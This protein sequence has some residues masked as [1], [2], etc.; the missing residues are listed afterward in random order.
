MSTRVAGSEDGAI[1]GKKR[2]PP[3]STTPAPTG[4]TGINAVTIGETD[5]IKAFGNATVSHHN[6]E[7]FNNALADRVPTPG[8]NQTPAP[9]ANPPGKERSNPRDKSEPPVCTFCHKRGH[10]A[11][12]CYRRLDLIT[13]ALGAAGRSI[14]D[15]YNATGAQPIP[16][17]AP[18]LVAATPRG[19]AAGAGYR[20]PKK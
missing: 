19:P 14:D 12:V 1:G 5:A 9:P 8:G 10:D 15:L 11:K 16:M 6:K 18:A 3:R 17:E 2:A 20:A 7:R 4:P 13:K